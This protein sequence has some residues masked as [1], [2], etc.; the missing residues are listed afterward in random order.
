[1]QKVELTKN[2]IDKISSNLTKT[3]EERKAEYRKSKTVSKPSSDPSV[4]T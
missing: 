2:S 4:Q 3:I 1:M